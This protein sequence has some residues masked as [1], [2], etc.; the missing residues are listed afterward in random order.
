[1]E[2]CCF[3]IV[4]G[5]CLL[6]TK[7]WSAL[8]CI[9]LGLIYYKIKSCCKGKKKHD[10][11]IK[12]DVK[13]KDVTTD[14]AADNP[15]PSSASSNKSFWS[16][17]T[18]ST[19]TFKIQSPIVIVDAPAQKVPSQKVPPQNKWSKVLAQHSDSVTFEEHDTTLAGHHNDFD[20]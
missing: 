8:E 19:A 11:P 1:M 7:S 3:F 18:N 12:N 6:L 5:G 10:L 4:R 20:L 2:Y 17:I 9:G 13:A 14:I 16:K 15:E